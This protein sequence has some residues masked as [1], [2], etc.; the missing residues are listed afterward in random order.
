ME[1]SR[2]YCQQPEPST[3]V[4]GTRLA[5]ESPN[6]LLYKVC[7][8]Q[9]QVS[10][11]IFLRTTR[12]TTMSAP[13]LLFNSHHQPQVLD[14]RDRYLTALA[15]VKA[16]EKEY[17]AYAHAREKALQRQRERRQVV[18]ALQQ[19]YDE[20]VRKQRLADALLMREVDLT[21][22]YPEH[23]Y[24]GTA[25]ADVYEELAARKALKYQ[26]H[27]AALVQQRLA[28]LQEHQAREQA[29]ARALVL[30][31][32]QAEEQARINRSSEEGDLK[33]I[34]N[35]LLDLGNSATPSRENLV[36]DLLSATLSQH[37]TYL[38]SNSISPQPLRLVKGALR[39]VH[40]V[41]NRPLPTLK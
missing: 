40:L 5:D 36:S 25:D 6:A 18:L 12:L 41:D 20:A 28:L 19:Q 15:E 7:V 3:R 14:P 22:G 37:L 23:Y 30:A 32:R 31:R 17:V 34:L 10:H 2:N 11:H 38:F 33:S 24:Y 26:Q 9:G 13:I 4:G 21:S 27:Q 8:S 39:T 35:L 16:A 1:S 29:K